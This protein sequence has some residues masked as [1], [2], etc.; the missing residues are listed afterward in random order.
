MPSSPTSLPPSRRT[1]LPP[2][3]RWLLRERE[4]VVGRLVGQQE[5]VNA[6]RQAVAA[7]EHALSVERARLAELEATAAETV[8]VIRALETSIRLGHPGAERLPFRPVRQHTRFGARGSLIGFLLE[9]TT[10]AGVDGITT[11]QLVD[12]AAEAFGMPV[13]TSKER[14]ALRFTVRSRMRELRD[15]HGLVVGESRAGVGKRTE[16]IWRLVAPMSLEE[17]R[18]DAV[19]R[20]AAVRSAADE[21]PAHSNSVRGEV[22]G[23]RV[24][25]AGRRD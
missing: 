10:A 1:H 17:L 5:A 18:Q 8:S 12:R 21:H 20:G 23:K 6:Q 14:E 9:A 25:D 22:A 4:V 15:L 2:E 7:L 11:G 16:I 3:L 24:G 13:A 19:A